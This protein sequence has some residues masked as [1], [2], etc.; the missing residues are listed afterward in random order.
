MKLSGIPSPLRLPIHQHQSH[1]CDLSLLAFHDAGAE[2][3]YL[4]RACRTLLTHQYRSGMMW[5]HGAQELFISDAHLRA[6][7]D[8]TGNTQDCTLSHDDRVPP[9]IAVH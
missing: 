1:L 5:N 2:L 6:D 9:A 7:P 4:R 3:S 8:P